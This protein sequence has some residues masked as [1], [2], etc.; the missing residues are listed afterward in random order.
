MSPIGGP[1]EPEQADL[2]VS[3]C[4]AEKHVTYRETERSGH[5]H[6]QPRF[7]L[8]LALGLDELFLKVEPSESAWPET[9]G[10]DVLV[11]ETV[12]EITDQT[13][14]EQSEEWEV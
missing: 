9:R 13:S 4:P 1:G 8:D 11:P 7:R 2:S 12:S 10:K 14:N 6:W 5:G 3:P